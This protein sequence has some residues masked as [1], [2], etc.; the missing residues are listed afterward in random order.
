MVRLAVYRE[1]SLTLQNAWINTPFRY[2]I[3]KEEA[4]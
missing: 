2:Y 1:T 4:I 3:F